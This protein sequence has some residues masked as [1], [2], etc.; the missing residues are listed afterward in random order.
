MPWRKVALTKRRLTVIAAADGEFIPKDSDKRVVPISPKLYELLQSYYDPTAE[1]VIPRGGVVYKNIW[2]DSGVILKR[3][4]VPRYAKPIHALR[5][6]C[7]TDWATQVAA[8][9]VMEWAGH[10]DIKTTLNHYLKVS[11]L[12]YDRAAGIASTGEQPKLHE[13]ECQKAAAMPQPHEEE[14]AASSSQLAS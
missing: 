2:R 5:K 8:H 13:A 12:E 4:G 9:V 3:A 10:D 7:I 6:S 14:N 1:F 11:E